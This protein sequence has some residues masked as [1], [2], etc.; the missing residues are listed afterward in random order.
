MTNRFQGDWPDETAEKPYGK[1]VNVLALVKDCGERY[2]FLYD[3]TRESV[4]ALFC[5]FGKY[6]S[7]PNLSF[8]WYE[9]AVFSQKARRLQ[10]QKEEEQKHDDEFG[11]GLE[12]E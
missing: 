10:M 4:E 5:Q 11:E 3:D 12:L 9:A 7:D 6:A 8:T 2:I 1:P